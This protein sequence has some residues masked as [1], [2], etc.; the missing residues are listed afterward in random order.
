M[1]N[2]QALKAVNKSAASAD[3]EIRSEL[4]KTAK[5]HPI[6]RKITIMRVVYFYF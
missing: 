1:N 6:T 2:K 4:E 5:V 3:K